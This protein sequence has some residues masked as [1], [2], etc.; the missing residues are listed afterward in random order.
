[1]INAEV[2]AQRR[3]LLVEQVG[4]GLILLPG[5]KLSAMNY[6]D[7]HYGFRQDG[8]F[9]YYFGLNMPD[10]AGTI[11]AD[12]GEA[13]LFGHEPTID[14]VVWTGPQPSFEDL[15]ASVGVSR[16]AAPGALAGHLAEASGRQI[17]FLPQYRP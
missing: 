13:T 12:T 7:N 17:Q 16:T 4:S 2:F 8:S 15:A 3:K 14:D 11:D 10:L 5:N 9:R 6:P 1:M